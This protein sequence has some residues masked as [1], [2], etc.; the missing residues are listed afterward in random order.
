MNQLHPV[1][2]SHSFITGSRID[3]DRV[4]PPDLDDADLD[5][6][7]EKLSE[8]PKYVERIAPVSVVVGTDIIRGKNWT[9]MMVKSYRMFLRVFTSIAYYIRQALAEKFDE[10]GM[11]P[12]MS[13]DVDPDTLHRIIELDYE[14]GE[15]TYGTL[16]D[17]FRSG[18]MAPA[19]T[20]PFH[21]ILPL[22][23]SDFDRRLVI[24][25][26]L[27]IYWKMVKEYHAYVKA[28]HGESAFVVPFWLPECGY[29]SATLSIL[30]EEFSAMAKADKIP[31]AHLVVMLDNQQTRDRDLDVLMKS[32][33]IARVNDK[34]TI[35]LVFR[36]K[37]FSEWVTYSNPSVKKL[38]D[39]TIAKVDSE[40]NELE[41]N[42]CW[43]HF[44]E[45][46]AL[47]FSSKAAQSFEQKVVKLAQLSYM[48][49]SPDFFARR[50]MSG[51][52]G[53]SENEPMEVRLKE[54]TGWGDWHTSVSLGRWEGVLDSNAL[55]KLVDEN[56]PYVR[57]TRTG[58]VQETGPQCW[59]IAFNRARE[60]CAKAVKGD[61]ET[62]KGG[63]LE[64]LAGI[65]GS[66]DAKVVRRNVSEFLVHYTL[67]HWRE[68]FIQGD[69]SEADLQLREVAG[70]YLMKDCRKRLKD[71]DVVMAGIAAQA[72]Y[73]ALDSQ[74]S[75]ATHYENMDQRAVYQNVAMLVL[76]MS[77]YATLLHWLG[78][79]QD[80]KKVVELIKSELI[81]FPTAYT[82]YRLAD[83][84]VTEQEWRDSIKSMIDETELTVV[85]RAARRVAARHLRPLGYRKDFT[86][87]DEHLTTN[88]GHIW[89][90]EIENT[91]YK[92]ENKLFCGM[93]EE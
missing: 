27:L 88:T 42:Y 6:L 16:M 71:E 40:L 33:N 77:N 58:K 83:Y 29:S 13:C 50:K 68:H 51:K 30:Q 86:R 26:G 12:F 84:G 37:G 55:F 60:I 87:E 89:S 25:M 57:R 23:D 34:D 31:D 24:R 5:E 38:I 76:A 92:W 74:R 81:D 67:I 61:P 3:I 39:R 19:A 90:A 65:C 66:K 75:H 48:A 63:V 41:I 43:G 22:L 28:A 2:H 15:N 54:N 53:R 72:Y 70:D 17:L 82:R 44:E 78:R 80:A 20:T 10:R 52:F 59:K 91:N 64:I 11:I 62:L 9:E 1:Y 56:H 4:L 79:A 73:F 45:I 36:D 49:V 46:E 8:S 32:W 21:A 18:V 7:I 47:A 35:S 69:M 85:A 14:Q 93:R